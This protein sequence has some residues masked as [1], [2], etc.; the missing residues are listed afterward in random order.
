MKTPI[1]RV[2]SICGAAVLLVLGSA[3]RGRLLAQARETKPASATGVT[4][5]Y[6]AEVKT[7]SGVW[8]DEARGRDVPVK[9]Y[10]PATASVPCPIIVFSH[11]LGG[12]REGY[13]Y[14]GE[15]WAAHGYVSVHLQHAGSDDAVWR[16]ATRKLKAMKDA[17]ADPEVVNARPLDV[18]FAIDRLTALATDEGFAPHGRLDLARI[19]VAGH[20]FGA[21]TTMAVAGRDYARGGAATAKWADPRVKAAVAMS[22]PAP[23][24]GGREPSTAGYDAVRIPVFHFTGT[25]DTDPMGGATTPAH[26]RIPYDHTTGAEA[27]LVTLDGGDHMVFGGPMQGDG[28][29][30]RLRASRENRERDPEFHALIQKTTTAF[31]DAELKGDERARA[32]LDNGGL[33]AAC[34]GLGKLEHKVP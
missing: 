32:W 31:W 25:L 24:R 2:A 18:R 16:D 26:R 5:A 30:A 20:S 1:L 6:A 13:A 34:A 7:W 11:G 9:I 15:Y 10:Y 28:R 17:M 3:C 22:T 12:T 19:G 27:W 14:L 23:S 29:G 4:A 8:R 33:A 21:F